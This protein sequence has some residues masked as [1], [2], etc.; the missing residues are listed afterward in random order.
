M[1]AD[2]LGICANATALLLLLW[3]FDRFTLPP[4]PL[5]YALSPL[6]IERNQRTKAV[7]KVGIDSVYS[8]V[9]LERRL[10]PKDA[11]SMAIATLRPATYNE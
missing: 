6:Q 9:Y 4:P 2:N 8:P 1:S 3:A 11:W 5:A 10:V 7:Q